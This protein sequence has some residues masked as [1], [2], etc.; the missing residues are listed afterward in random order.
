VTI[1]P[2]FATKRAEAADSMLGFMKAVP[3][4]ARLSATSSRKTWTGR[5]LRRSLLAWL[6]PTAEP[7]EDVRR[8]VPAR[9]PSSDSK[10]HGSSWSRCSSSTKERLAMIGDKEADRQIERDKINKDFEAKL[11]GIA[12]DLETKLFAMVQEPMTRIAEQVGQMAQTLD[13]PPAA[14]VEPAPKAEPKA[15]PQPAPVL[16]IHMP[17]G[18]KKI[19]RQ[20]DNSL[21]AEDVE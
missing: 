9:S 5:A 1:G 19:T 3:R 7:A 13:N 10:P 11:T 16:H 21:V 2:S 8:Q 15:E 14:P 4:P 18:K 6:L 20:P 12:A 17:S